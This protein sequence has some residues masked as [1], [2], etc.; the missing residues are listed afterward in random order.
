MGRDVFSR[1]SLSPQGLVVHCIE[2][3]GFPGDAHA[4]AHAGKDSA[5]HRAR[6][7]ASVAQPAGMRIYRVYFHPGS[8]VFQIVNRSHLPPRTRHFPERKACE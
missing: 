8:P 2:A 6:F 4:V 5:G 7:G 1:Q 3:P